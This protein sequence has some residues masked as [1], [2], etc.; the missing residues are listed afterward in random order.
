MS[1]G[2]IGRAA[3][4]LSTNYAG[5][6]TGLD[7]AGRDARAKAEGIGAGVNKSLAA[8]SK[9]GGGE[10]GGFL[11]G[12]A[13]SALAAGATIAAV[14][15]TVRAAIASIGEIDSQA[16]LAEAL[17]ISTQGFMGLAAA[18]D[19]FDVDTN[20]L[21]EG[22][23]KSSA[24]AG[25][26]LKGGPQAEAFHKLGLDA[27]AVQGL[28][29]EDT[30]YT[31]ADALGK[32]QDPAERARLGLVLFGEE[33][34]KKLLP[35][36]AKGGD[37]IRGIV[38]E[39]KKLGVAL[40]AADVGKVRAAQAAIT[41]AGAA[42]QGLWNKIVVAIAPVIELG[43]KTLARFAPVF[44]W[45][46]RAATA[47]Y[48]IMAA[49]WGAVIDAIG[50]A[51]NA[52]GDWLSG[53][54]EL[55]GPWPSIEG[56]ITDVLRAIVKAAAYAWDA[57]KAGLGGVTMAVSYL[58]EGFGGLVEAL[59]G[60]VDLAKNLP[61]DL[62]PDWLDGLGAGIDQFA[63]KTKGAAEDMRG[64][65]ERQMNAFGENATLVDAWFDRLKAKKDAV[66][67]INPKIG[68]VDPG[69]YSPNN[70][71]VKGTKEELSARIKAEFGGATLAEKQL[72][73]QKKTT[74]AAEATAAAVKQVLEKAPIQL[75]LI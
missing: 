1:Q 2:T 69:K 64:W 50:E 59:G 75:G 35:L 74:K 3:L 24:A 7:R 29:I 20:G 51:V 14:T 23:I 66:E 30:V 12:I 45:I 28:G 18:A 54:L 9:K 25:E 26:A 4:V 32:V 8:G 58:V 60:V 53:V 37:G 34:G 33:A 36:L 41:R 43:A 11:A 31:F 10:G 16:R 21:M 44:D 62:R 5:M 46:G 65:G 61:D 70:A 48:G 42:L 56:V 38:D 27:Q 15:G 57:L 17:G 73:E 13:G 47:Y 71:L 63:A 49:I 19:R 22:L 6:S 67:N 39:S 40:N 72:A 68:T 55:S 52:L